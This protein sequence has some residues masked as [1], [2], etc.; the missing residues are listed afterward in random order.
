MGVD[1]HRTYVL[2]SELLQ[3]FA[4]LI[5]KAVADR[6]RSDI[7]PLV[8]DRLATGEAPDVI[9]EA[10]MLLA[11]LLIAPGI[12]DHSLHFTRR[13]DHA[14]RIQDAF[15]IR[16]IIG[17][18]FVIVKVVKALPEDLTLLQHQIPA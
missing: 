4:D 16:I 9:A 10:A 15:H 11:Y 13:A 2:E 8:E 5:R 14:F 18:D 3:V 1:R 17:C 6:D 7:M 12:I